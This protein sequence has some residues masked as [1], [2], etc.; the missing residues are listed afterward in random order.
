MGRPTRKS[1][2]TKEGQE[3]EDWIYGEPPGRIT[4][5]TFT[6]GKVIFVKETYA[7]LGGSIARTSPEK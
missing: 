6:S 1:R 4:F 2:E 3:I 7:G 5:V